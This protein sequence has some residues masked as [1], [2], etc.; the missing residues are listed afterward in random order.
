MSTWKPRGHQIHF[1][2]PIKTVF[3]TLAGGGAW[4]GCVGQHARF[5]GGGRA[6]DPVFGDTIG[7]GIEADDVTV[8]NPKLGYHPLRRRATINATYARHFN[9]VMAR[10]SRA[11]KGGANQFVYCR[12]P[13]N[14]I[15]GL[16]RAT[17]SARK[18]AL[19]RSRSPGRARRS[20]KQE[21]STLWTV[22][23]SMT[24]LGFQRRGLIVCGQLFMGRHVEV[25]ITGKA[26]RRRTRSLLI[27]PIIPSD[28]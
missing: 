17:R 20:R 14:V 21:E 23:V 6:G 12:A 8:R 10:P 7:R 11:M 4:E 2:D 18:V 5:P 16:V 3:W 9:I 24:G 13:P 22:G 28:D 1:R 26:T 25:E 15:A 19:C 27:R